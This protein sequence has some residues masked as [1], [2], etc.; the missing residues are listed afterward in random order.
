MLSIAV[1]NA[2]LVVLIVLIAHF[3]LKNYLYEKSAH[4]PHTPP[5]LPPKPETERFA[6]ESTSSQV[7]ELPAELNGQTGQTVKS[8]ADELYKFVFNDETPGQCAPP[9]PALYVPEPATLKA[10]KEPTKQSLNQ[11]NLVLN[12][13]E[14]ES[15]LNGGALF[16]ALSAFDSYAGDYVTL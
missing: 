1:K 8:E 2:I 16:G 14:N 6:D 3:L 5:T 9:Q 12:E 7:T 13:Y 15:V 4:A 10:A 11:E